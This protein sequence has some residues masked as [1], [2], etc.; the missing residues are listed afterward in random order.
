MNEKINK[1][2]DMQ[3]ILDAMLEVSKENMKNLIGDCLSNATLG[4]FAGKF[5]S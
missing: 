5:F 3:P 4:V 1:S 2:K